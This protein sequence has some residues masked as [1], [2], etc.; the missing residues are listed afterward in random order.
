MNKLVLLVVLFALFPLSYANGLGLGSETTKLNIGDKKIEVTTQITPTEFSVE[1][2]KKI[3]FTVTDT[4]ESKNI[5][6][7]LFVTMY[8]D[9]NQVFKENFRTNNGIVQINVKPTQDSEVKISGTYD[10]NTL[11]WISKPE[12][13]LTLSGPVLNSGGLYRF[14]VE[15]KELGSTALQNQ[16][17]SSYISVVTNYTY[18]KQDKAGKSIPF[19]IKSYYE[20]ISS[21]EYSPQTNSVSFEMPFDWSEQNISH[22]DVVHEELHFPKEFADFMVPSYSGTV[23]GI[24]LFKSAV[25]I[26]DYSIEQQ[27]I[28][29]LVL[30]QDTIR[31]LRQ[32]QKSAGTDNPQNM[33][34]TLEVGN[35]LVFP[36]IA[37]TKDGAIQVDL[38]WDPKTIEPG[39]NAKFI[40]TFRDAKTGDL[41]R[42]TSYD[43]VI[44]Q[45]GN[46]IYKKSSNAKIGGDYVDYTF[47]DSQKGPTTIQF[48]NLRGTDQQT[49]I[50]L[51]VAPEFGTLTMLILVLAITTGMIASRQKFF[52]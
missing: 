18:E 37:Q 49:Q 2:Q 33:H 9:G 10:K 20:K 39:K 7:V 43:F 40:F 13:P 30:S 27:R 50:S 47:T 45:N 44:I 16:V 6:A 4:N 8:H 29:H 24:S 42:D 26:D 35:N 5:D 19:E 28:V 15:I 23:N 31:Y 51:V 46:E 36:V 1:S 12:M 38:S 21:F 3:T 25:I 22:I 41:L 34:F 32:A 52:R 14:D 48:K 17:F 11:Y